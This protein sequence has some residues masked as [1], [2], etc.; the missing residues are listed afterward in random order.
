MKSL[1][2]LP[3]KM[4]HWQVE[5]EDGSDPRRNSAKKITQVRQEIRTLQKETKAEF[6]T[7]PASM[8]T[9]CIQVWGEHARIDTN[10]AGASRSS[11]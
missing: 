10:A 4:W 8:S 2:V 7:S 1:C 9:H 11:L 5:E 3:G 6:F